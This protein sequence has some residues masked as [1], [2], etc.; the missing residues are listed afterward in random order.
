[1]IRFT[2]LIAATTLLIS[3][4]G[5]SR[6]VRE[7]RVPLEQPTPAIEGGSATDIIDA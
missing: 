5:C 7:A 2:L 4:T 1:M 3:T 6:E